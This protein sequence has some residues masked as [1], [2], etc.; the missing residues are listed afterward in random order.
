MVDHHL[1]KDHLLIINSIRG[2]NLLL[3]SVSSC[4]L[5]NQRKPFLVDKFQHFMQSLPQTS[6]NQAQIN[7][8]TSQVIAKIEVRSGQMDASIGGRERT[9]FKSDCAK[10]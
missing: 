10:T 9:I 1:F 2:A 4:V 7:H 6:Q 5:P 3:L 8:A